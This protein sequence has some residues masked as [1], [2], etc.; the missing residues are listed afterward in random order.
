MPDT[1]SLLPVAKKRMLA[2]KFAYYFGEGMGPPLSLLES[3]ADTKGN[4]DASSQSTNEFGGTTVTLKPGTEQAGEECNTGVDRQAGQVK[5]KAQDEKLQGNVA[6]SLAHE[7]WQEGEI[8]EGHL[9]VEDGSQC[10]LKEDLGQPFFVPRCFGE[11]VFTAQQGTN[12]QIDEVGRANIFDDVIRERHDQEQARK[13]ECDGSGLDYPSSCDANAGDNSR[14]APLPSAARQ[15]IKHIW[16]RY[17][18]DQNSRDEE[19]KNSGERWHKQDS[20]LCLSRLI[21]RLRSSIFFDYI[22][23]LSQRQ[24]NSPIFAPGK[25]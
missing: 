10:A 19:Q 12:T 24:V 1:Y 18:A 17:D 9:W 23:V 13:A 22:T 4:E 21:V 7:L 15:N 20:L 25:R 3:K 8:K 11:Q 6:L 14:S 2:N 16:S 5:E